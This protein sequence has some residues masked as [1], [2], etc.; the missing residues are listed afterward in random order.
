MTRIP[1]P[2]FPF[3]FNF[4]GVDWTDIHVNAN[5]IVS[6]GADINDPPPTQFFDNTDFFN[7]LPKIAAYFMD[8]DPSANGGVFVKSEAS[9]LRL[10]SMAPTAPGTR[11]G[12]ERSTTWAPT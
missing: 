7:E 2:A 11:S 6:F 3:T 4:Y 9:R 12:R 5:G 1:R 10:Y 8:L